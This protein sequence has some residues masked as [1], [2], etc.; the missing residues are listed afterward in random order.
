MKLYGEGEW[1]VRKHGYSTY[2]PH[3]EDTIWREFRR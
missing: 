2:I 3:V 1:K